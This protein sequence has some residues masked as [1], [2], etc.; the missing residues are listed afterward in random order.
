MSFHFHHLR[1]LAQFREV[2]SSWNDLWA[3]SETTLPVAQAEWITQWMQTFR[4]DAEFHALAVEEDGKLVAA[5][6][7]VGVKKAKLL[8]VG[9][10]PRNEWSPCGDLLWDTSADTAALDLLVRG[11]KQLPWPILMLNGIPFERPDW[12]A[13]LNAAQMAN[14]AIHT[15]AKAQVGLVDCTGDWES[16]QAAWSSNHRRHMRKSLRKAEAEGQI[17]LHVLNQFS[18]EHEIAAQVQRGF[19]VEDRSWKGTGTNSSVLKTPGLIDYYIRQAQE[20]AAHGQLQLVFLEFN[21]QPIAFEYGWLAKGTYFTPK[22]GYDEAFARFTPGQL[23]R[24]LLYEKLNAE[25]EVHNV[26]FA[27][28]LSNATAKW[29][30]ETYPI[31]RVVVGCGSLSSRWLLTGYKTIREFR[32]RRLPKPSATANQS[33]PAELETVSSS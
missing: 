13:F 10:L 28:E 15:E 8:K 6:P 22:V 5:L 23:L 18:D 17:A 14:L 21:G 33:V 1:S 2:S 31:G 3:R 11:F 16:I 4:S 7:I 20:A 30:T 9:M 29:T 19:A 27:G 25:R 24:Y 32:K 26:D 12:Q